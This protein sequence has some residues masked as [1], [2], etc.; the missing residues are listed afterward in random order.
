MKMKKFGVRLKMESRP[1]WLITGGAGYI[2]SEVFAILIGN[3]IECLVL[4]DLSAGV[5]ERVASE[6]LR[7]GSILD[8]TF[9]ESIFQSNEIIGVIHLAAKKDVAEAEL[10][11]DEYHLVNVIGTENVFSLSKKYNVKHF[12][13]AS[14][15]A[16]YDSNIPMPHG[17]YNEESPIFNLGVYG[18]SKILSEKGERL[19]TILAG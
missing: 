5:R 1:K 13:F 11:P 18:N 7:I 15:A 14:T 6:S 17:G 16:V 10:M 8:L 4:D 2:G 3:G 19:G 9:L 12:I